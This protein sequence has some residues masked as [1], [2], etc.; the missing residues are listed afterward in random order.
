MPYA[1]A[2]STS[3]S[4]A[5]IAI[6]EDISMLAISTYNLNV[7]DNNNCVATQSYTITQGDSIQISLLATNVNCFNAM[8]GAINSNLIGGSGPLTYSWSTSTSAVIISTLS[9]IANLDTGLYVLTVQ[10]SLGCSASDSIQIVQPDSIQ[11]SF[12]VSDVTCNGLLDG[13]I[14]L[15]VIGGTGTYTYNWGNS[16]VSQDLNN[17]ASGKYVVTI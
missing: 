14:D 12:V 16:Q 2:W 9:S 15:T 11:A 3:T 6:S 1:Y 13:S 10:D 4:S 8:D 5:T 7:T 17:I